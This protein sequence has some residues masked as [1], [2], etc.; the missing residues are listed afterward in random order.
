MPLELIQISGKMSRFDIHELI[1]SNASSEAFREVMFQ[2]EVFR[3][4]ALCSVVVGYQRFRG[5][6]CL[7][8]RCGRKWHRYRPRLERGTAPWT[9]VT[10]VSYHN[11][12]RRQNSEDLDLKHHRRERFKTRIL[13]DSAPIGLLSGFHYGTVG[14]NL[15]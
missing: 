6:C 5:P 8:G 2:V 9:S 11:T 12:T 3:V 10:L 7:C 13:K 14:Q 15:L 1:N 4:V